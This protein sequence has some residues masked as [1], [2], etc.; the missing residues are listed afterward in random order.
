MKSDRIS[1]AANASWPTMRDSF[2]EARE[3]EMSWSADTE[4]PHSDMYEEGFEGLLR[5]LRIRDFR[6]LNVTE[7]V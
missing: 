7:R 1:Q 4:L 5:E 2:L 6:T 3:E